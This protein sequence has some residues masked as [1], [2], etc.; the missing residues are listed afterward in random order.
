MFDILLDYQE[1]QRP[2]LSSLL[3]PSEVSLE[4]SLNL[5]CWICK[6]AL[7]FSQASLKSEIA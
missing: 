2:N 4:T 3:L 7:C 5:N 6:G 1:V